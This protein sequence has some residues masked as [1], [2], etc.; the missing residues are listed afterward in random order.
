MT[1]EWSSTN[2]QKTEPIPPSPA[3]AAPGSASRV[4]GV[5]GSSP[6]AFEADTDEGAS[7]V[8]SAVAPG[9]SAPDAQGVP[10]P[11]EVPAEGTS[12]GADPVDGVRVTAIA[13]EGSPDGE[14]DVRMPPTTT[15]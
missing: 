6:D 9:S 11:S 5:Q 13:P 1:E 14:T 12:E 2:Q 8:S 7:N 4:P 3:H 15:F 10:V